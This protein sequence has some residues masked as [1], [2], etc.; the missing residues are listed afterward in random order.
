[1]GAQKTHQ[2]IHFIRFA[3]IL[4]QL[5]WDFIKS[6][7]LFLFSRSFFILKGLISVLVSF[8]L[9]TNYRSIHKIYWNLI[10]NKNKIFILV[11]TDRIVIHRAFSSLFSSFLFI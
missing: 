5:V 7:L 8:K 4:I 9:K 2:E 3:F 10:L 1:M 6:E 11:K